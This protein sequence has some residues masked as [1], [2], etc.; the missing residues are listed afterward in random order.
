MKFVE[1]PMAN[2]LLLNR[3]RS[4]IGDGARLSHQMNAAKSTTNASPATTMGGEL[5]PRLAPF[6][7]ASRKV[8][9][10]AVDNA[11]PGKSY[12]RLRVSCL[13]ACPLTT[14]TTTNMARTP[15]TTFT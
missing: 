1:M 5:H 2:T 11:A 10:T 9:S 15:I 14:A 7:T 3:P 12:D 6:D 13:K 8:T 4:N